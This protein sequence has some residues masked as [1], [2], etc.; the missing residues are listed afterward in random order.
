MK[1]DES[2]QRSPF[3]PVRARFVRSKYLRIAPPPPAFRPS[4]RASPPL[5]PAKRCDRLRHLFA[6]KSQ[7]KSTLLAQHKTKYKNRP[8]SPEPPRHSRIYAHAATATTLQ[9]T[10]YDE[11]RVGYSLDKHAVSCKKQP[12]N[13]LVFPDLP[14]FL[15]NRN[16]TQT[17]RLTEQR[18]RARP[19]HSA[20][21]SPCTSY[22]S[23]ATSKYC[24]TSAT[25]TRTV[26]YP[27]HPSPAPF[28]FRA[29]VPFEHCLFCFV[30]F[31]QNRM[32][33]ICESFLFPPCA[34]KDSR[35][36]ARYQ[37]QRILGGGVDFSKLVEHLLPAAEYRKKSP[38][39]SEVERSQVDKLNVKNIVDRFWTREFPLPPASPRPPLTGSRLC[40]PSCFVTHPR[41]RTSIL[42]PSHQSVNGLCYDSSVGCRIKQKRLKL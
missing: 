17:D 5:P 24:R 16:P 32:L 23:P 41:R 28:R 2:A 13:N 22:S 12:E 18:A 36:R 9:H 30:G 15:R 7:R 21:K 11:G 29:F 33:I 34:V 37:A 25:G 19:P 27:A 35:L 42:S 1:R 10:N 40:P 39:M 38:S 8:P 31:S 4:P 26:R 6:S 14:R 3:Q 20:A